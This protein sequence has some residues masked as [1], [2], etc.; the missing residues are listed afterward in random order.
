MISIGPQS[1][2][3]NVPQ[4]LP[5]NHHALSKHLQVSS[6]LDGHQSS[7]RNIPQSQ[8]DN[9]VLYQKINVMPLTLIDISHRKE[10]LLY[11]TITIFL[12]NRQQDPSYLDRYQSSERKKSTTST[13]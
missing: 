1:S 8:P 5:R 10:T 7:E 13:G 9:T 3:R 11:Q 2:E 12:P 4:S 6:N